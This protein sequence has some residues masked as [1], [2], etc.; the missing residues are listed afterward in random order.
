[1]HF[2][3]IR[4]NAMIKRLLTLL[5]M[6]LALCCTTFSANYLTFTAEED[7]SS[8][9]IEDHNIKSN[10][11]YSLNNGKTWKQL[12]GQPVSL[13]KGKRA[14]L[15][16]GKPNGTPSWR[17]YSSFKMEGSIAASGSVMSLVDGNGEGKTIPHDYCFYRL[18]EH[19]SSL[20]K[21]PELL[22]TTLAD[23]CYY[24]MFNGC[25]NLAKAPELPAT[26]LAERCY[27]GMFEG[28]TNL[29]QAPQLPANTLA[30]GCYCG[31]FSGCT[32]LRQAPELPAKKLTEGCYYAMFDG[33]A[34][35]TQ[36]PELPATTLANKHSMT[37][38]PNGWREAFISVDWGKILKLWTPKPSLDNPDDEF[39]GWYSDDTYTTQVHEWDSVPTDLYA[40]W[41]GI[42]YE[43][44]FENIDWTVLQ[45]WMVDRGEMPDYLWDTPTFG[46]YTSI[47]R[48]PEISIVTWD[49]TYVAKYDFWSG[50]MVN[51][52]SNDETL[53]NI[54]KSLVVVN[55][56]D[57]VVISW[58]VV[59]IWNQ[60]IMAA[61]L[62]SD[63]PYY[64]YVFTGWTN[65]CW[66][67]VTHDCGLIANFEEQVAEYTVS[68]SSNNT[69][70]WV[71]DYDEFV[72]TY[73]N[74]FDVVGNKVNIYT[75]W[76]KPLL[77]GTVTATATWNWHIFSGWTTTCE[78][79]WRNNS[80]FY[81]V[82][83]CEFVANFEQE[84]YEVTWKNFDRTTLRVD[85]H[86][87]GDIPSYGSTPSYNGYTFIWWIP[88][89]SPVTWDVTYLA[90]Y[91]V[92]E[93]NV[94]VVFS[95]NNWYW[96]SVNTWLI[97]SEIW[98]NV[99]MSG[100]TVIVW[101]QE[102]VATPEVDD[103]MYRYNF[104]NWTNT[105]WTTLTENCELIANFEEEKY[106]CEVV[107]KSKNWVELRTDLI[108]CWSVPVYSKIIDSSLVCDG[109]GVGGLITK[110]TF[111]RRNPE[112]GVITDDVIYQAVCVSAMATKRWTIT[113]NPNNSEYWS[114][115]SKKLYVPQWSSHSVFMFGNTVTINNSTS[116]AL[117]REEN[118]QY[119]YIFTWWTNGCRS[120]IAGNCTITGN[121]ER[122][123]REYPIVFQNYDC[124]SIH[125]LFLLSFELNF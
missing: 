122:V 62:V 72:V 112:V 53:W 27:M 60:E 22:A 65:T 15:K 70:Y 25:T 104:I 19:C 55:S 76:T 44:I 5:C 30:G 63:D 29:K 73:D 31:M 69:G 16:G 81:L 116:T 39:L 40:K 84:V 117:P 90:N 93:D 111:D 110:E 64:V 54:N 18:F 37:I 68:F 34:S 50:L 36:A 6:Q 8:F 95:P 79:D 45:S 32:S 1:M 11:F 113:I 23:C 66:N 14:L 67:T 86:V 107:W 94:A 75:L 97:I 114:I 96:W 100:N 125:F 57:M 43:V 115:S 28:C 2:T 92:W 85:E 124:L 20:T 35:L 33:C 101:D 13:A 120:P 38:H 80:R 17:N 41:K 83:W 123:I 108:E 48:S 12:T 119:S 71:V 82:E 52:S 61:P 47:W 21:A 102:I 10:I 87:Y 91:D 51:I 103:G 24:S 42:Q 56:G 46:W 89:I 109:G 106:M 105:C 4:T 121:F 99:W 118:K 78:P 59:T 7:N 88:G 9:S 3:K 26:T 98:S 49:I 58:N 74:Y 77:I